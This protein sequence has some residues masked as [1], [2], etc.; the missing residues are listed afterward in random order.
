LWVLLGIGLCHLLFVWSGDILA[1]YALVGL[2]LV[3]LRNMPDQALW[4]WVVLLLVLPV[5][6]WAVFWLSGG[7]ECSRTR[8]AGHSILRRG[9]GLIQ[10][11]G[12]Q[13]VLPDGGQY[14]VGLCA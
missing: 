6:L 4:R 9:L 7:L 5:P 12:R 1:F 2:L 3:R 8:H 14:G 13:D 11:D 10:G